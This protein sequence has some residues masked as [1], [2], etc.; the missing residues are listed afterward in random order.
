MTVLLLLYIFL[1]LVMS[2]IYGNTALFEFDIYIYKLT[3]NLLF[4]L[5]VFLIPKLFRGMFKKFDFVEVSFLFLIFIFVIY[6]KL[7]LAIA[8]IALF[9][10]PNLQHIMDKLV[11]WAF[12]LSI[13]LLGI[14]LSNGV[15]VIWGLILASFAVLSQIVISI[16]LVRKFTWKDKVYLALAQ[17]NGITS[18]VLAVLIEKA[19]PG[20]I[21]I[22]A[23][24]LFFIN[25][26][27]YIS[28]HIADKYFQYSSCK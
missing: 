27:Y 15:Q 4:A 5:V 23:P 2:L 14:F 24:T 16:I 7:M 18:I 1:P 3:F 12:Y 13:I 9:L 10:R 6:F 8:L 26:L 21:S 22:I 17:Q 19:F 20:T 28:G 11:M 25:I